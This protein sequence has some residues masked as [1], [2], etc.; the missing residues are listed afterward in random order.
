MHPAPRDRD[1]GNNC[2]SLSQ[3][4]HCKISH[5]TV[6]CMVFLLQE[7]HDDDNDDGL[8]ELID[9]SDED[10]IP[11][12]ETSRSRFALHL[13]YLP[14]SLCWNRHPSPRADQV[15]HVDA[16]ADAPA[17]PVLVV[18]L[19]GPPTSIRR[20]RRGRKQGRRHLRNNVCLRQR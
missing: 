2:N 3:L 12:E 14:T 4:P 7:H 9:L 16:P 11:S 1:P 13:L 17:A 15:L 8:P 20:R 10:I 5:S 19:Q 18:P 6:A